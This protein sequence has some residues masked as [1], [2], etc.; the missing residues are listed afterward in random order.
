MG[1]CCHDGLTG[2]MNAEPAART[3]NAHDRAPYLAPRTST[4]KQIQ[5]SSR[6]E[7]TP[8]HFVSTRSIS[9]IRPAATLETLEQWSLIPISSTRA[10]CKLEGQR[11]PRKEGWIAALAFRGRGLAFIHFV[12]AALRHGVRW[13]PFV[14]SFW[15]MQR[16]RKEIFVRAHA[17]AC[18]KHL[19]ARP[20]R[21]KHEDC[22]SEI[23]D[24][25]SLVVKSRQDLVARVA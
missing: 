22:M 14:G 17:H 25:V 1:H 23:R 3:T 7:C 10:K 6:F 11:S 5:R 20:L 15:N 18:Q 19:A 9:R 24:G 21:D 8:K 13:I 12:S 16:W 2:E 4:E